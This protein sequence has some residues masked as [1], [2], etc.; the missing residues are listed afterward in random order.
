MIKRTIQEDI[1]TCQYI[2]SQS[3]STKIYK[4]TTK[5]TNGR[6]W[7]IR[8]IVGNLNMPLTAMVRLCKQKINM[9]LSALNDTLDQM[10]TIEIY[11]TF[12]PR[13]RDH[14]F[15]SSA[16]GT[17]S[18]MDHMLGLSSGTI[19]TGGF[20]YRETCYKFFWYL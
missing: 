2:V 4:A 8:N 7:Q 15:F 17:F 6:N 19:W 11:R 10:D 12:H 13:T 20:L 16:Q 1:N 5:R 14:T 3:E 9:E 18:R